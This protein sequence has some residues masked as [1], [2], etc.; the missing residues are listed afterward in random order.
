MLKASTELVS[1]A[2]TVADIGLRSSQEISPMISPGPSW[3][4]F[5]LEE[6]P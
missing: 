5:S 1:T 6:P 4:T 2:R 3:P